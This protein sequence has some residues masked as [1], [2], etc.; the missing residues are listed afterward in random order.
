LSRLW[1]LSVSM[2]ALVESRSCTNSGTV[3]TSNDSRSALPRPVEKGVAECAQRLYGICQPKY[4][5]IAELLWLVE[6]MW[7]GQSRRFLDACQQ[8]LAQLAHWVL[9]V[10]LQRRRQ[11]SVVAILL[12]WLLFLEM[13]L[14]ADFRTEQRR[15]VRVSVAGDLVGGRGCCKPPWDVLRSLALA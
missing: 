6:L 10:Q 1:P 7:R 9:P 5:H 13:R 2:M 15:G 11:R 3:G 14:R 4:P 8:P 12:R